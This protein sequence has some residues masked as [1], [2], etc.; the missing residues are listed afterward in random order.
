MEDENSVSLSAKQTTDPLT[1]S[2]RDLA[3]REREK[4]SRPIYMHSAEQLSYIQLYGIRDIVTRIV[5]QK[6]LSQQAHI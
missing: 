1:S 2:T 4:H 3:E 6:D 5:V